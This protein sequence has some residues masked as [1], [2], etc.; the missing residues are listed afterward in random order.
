SFATFPRRRPLPMVA[1][2]PES[3]AGAAA[4]ASEPN[5]HARIG[6]AAGGVVVM[7]LLV[8]LVQGIF[9]TPENLEIVGQAVGS[10]HI[11]Q[12]VGCQTDSSSIS[13]VI[14]LAVVDDG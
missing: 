13:D 12:G 1:A 14:S 4:S 8:V 10:G 7:D 6:R 9:Y 2:L 11:D 3:P 5:P